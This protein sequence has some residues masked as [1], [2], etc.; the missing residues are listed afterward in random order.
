MMAREQIYNHLRSFIVDQ[1]LD[2]DGEDLDADTRLLEVGIIDSM[3][4]INLIAFIER[5]FELLIPHADVTPTNF[6]TLGAVVDLV[7]RLPRQRSVS[8]EST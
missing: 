5:R 1:L 7:L 2:G 3:T 8:G 4:M 6:E